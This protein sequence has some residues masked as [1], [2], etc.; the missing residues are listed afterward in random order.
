MCS[1]RA[2]ALFNFNS[3]LFKTF[4]HYYLPVLIDRGQSSVNRTKHGPSFQLEKWLH[5]RYAIVSL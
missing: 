3:T 4:F 5:V 1:V 2:V